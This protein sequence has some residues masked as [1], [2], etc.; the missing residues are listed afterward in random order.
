MSDFANQ[1]HKIHDAVSQFLKTLGAEADQFLDEMGDATSKYD[2]QT[3]II[4][5]Q[6]Q[7]IQMLQHD[8]ARSAAEYQTK[9]DIMEQEITA[10]RSRLG[11]KD[12]HFTALTRAVN[13]AKISAKH[14]DAVLAHGLNIV[15]CDATGD[16]IVTHL[17]GRPERSMAHQY[18]SG[19]QEVDPGTPASPLRSAG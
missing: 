17:R 11:E 6:R 16:K 1:R 14:T 10:L 18:A 13:L 8:S 5:S 12:K 19:M 7:S 4:E 3:V 15:N 2:E 9:I